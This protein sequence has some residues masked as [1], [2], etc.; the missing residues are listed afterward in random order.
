MCVCRPSTPPSLRS[1]MLF[2][3]L[4]FC[5]VQFVHPARPSQRA[6]VLSV[7]IPTLLCGAFC[8]APSPSAACTPP[9]H[10]Q[11]L[12]LWQAASATWN[13]RPS[14]GVRASVRR[15]TSAPRGPRRPQGFPAGGWDF[16]ARPVPLH[17]PRCPRG[18]TVPPRSAPRP[19]ARGWPSACRGRCAWTRYGRRA[20]AGGTAPACGPPCVTAAPRVRGWHSVRCACWRGLRCRL[21]P[22]CAVGWAQQ[23][24]SVGPSICCRFRP[25]ICCRMGAACAVARARMPSCMRVLFSGASCMLC[26]CCVVMAVRCANTA[27]V[28]LLLL[29]LPCAM[30]CRLRLP[31]WHGSSHGQHGVL[32]P[33]VLLPDEQQR[34]ALHPQRLL[35]AAHPRGPVLQRHDVRAGVLLH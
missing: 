10:A 2:V 9:L 11:Q 1:P 30:P 27:A 14:P 5:T 7:S 29:L 33:R 6:C 12:L 34:P 13:V 21:G 35:R 17:P 16:T 4:S 20:R 22:A 28:L 32:L 25:S 3:R 8:C 26:F 31:G 19:T 24:L 15:G 18:F 23:A